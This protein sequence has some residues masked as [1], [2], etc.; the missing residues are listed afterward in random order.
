MYEQNLEPENEISLLDLYVILRRNIVLI[1][2]FTTLIAM[3]AAAYAFFVVDETY[4]SN[5]DVMVQVQ[6]DP[7]IDGSYDYNTAQKLLATIVEFMSKDVVLDE[8]IRDLDLSYT[9]TQLKNNLT[10]TSSNTSF[11]INIK[12][13]DKDPRLAK[14][15]V[16]SVINQSILVANGNDAFST[17]KNKITRTSFADMGV[18]EAPNKPLYVA[19]GII[20]GGIV[21][22]GFVFIKEL[23]NNS[24]RTKEQLEQAFDIQVMGTI[25]EF[26]VKEDF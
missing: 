25:P 1:L 15:I 20:L 18:Y 14:E 3:I 23:M 26:E 4:A 17:L 24:Y 16:D 11:F 9:T 12:Y 13:V 2:A 7:N 8:V 5:A 19:I 22:V 6:T 10:V 21:G